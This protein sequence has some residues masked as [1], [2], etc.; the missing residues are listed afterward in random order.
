[1]LCWTMLFWVFFW[2]F[3]KKVKV[4]TDNFNTKHLKTTYQNTFS[5]K[6]QKKSCKKFY[7]INLVLQKFKKRKEIKKKNLYGPSLLQGHGSQKLP[8][9]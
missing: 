8:W 4:L 3:S 6:K 9:P 7:Q 2:L 5:L 1:M